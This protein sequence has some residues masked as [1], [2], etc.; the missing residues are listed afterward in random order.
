M[1]ESSRTT[2][3]PS[4]SLDLAGLREQVVGM[5]AN[6][7]TPFGQRLMVYCDYTASGRSLHFIERYLQGLLQT[8]ANTHTEDD[9]TGRSTSQLLHEAER[10]IKR[11]AGAGERGKIVACG[12]GATGAIHKLQQIL[13]VAIAP[14]TRSLLEAQ[15][16][17]HFG[18]KRAAAFTEAQAASQPVVFV[19]PYEHHSNEIS[20][21]QGLA[22]VVEVRLAHDG[23]V[24]LEHLE[25][26][27]T[28]PR[29]AGRLR[30]GSFSAASNVTGMRS[31]VR[32]IARLLHR[33]DALAC[34]DYAASGPYVQIDMNPGDDDWLDAVFISPHKFLG[35]PGSSGILVFNERLYHRELAP[36]VAGGGTV[37]YVSPEDHD[38]IADIEERE[39]A[40]TPGIL[41]TLRAALAFEVKEAVTHEAI[42]SRELALLQR[43]FA[44]W[45]EADG[46]EIL[47]NP[48]PA[49]RIGIVSFNVRDA[50]GGYLHPKFATALL[51]DLFGIQSRAGCSCAG[52]YGHRLLGIGTDV[53]G[54]Y[55]D[56]V[57]KGYHGIKPGWCRIGFHYV[58]DDVDADYVIAAVRFIARSGHRFLPDYCFDP[59]SGAWLHRKAGPVGTS[60]SLAAA[61]A[62]AVPGLTALP[63][64]ERA[65]RFAGYL[66]EAE[67]LAQAAG[68][69][70]RAGEPLLGGQFGALQFFST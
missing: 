13:G 49:R 43:A 10:A 1:N 11:A 30:I 26:L 55:R 25:A 31:P 29:Y 58:M 62:A 21:R 4:P 33:H 8:Y 5:D 50:R 39:R 35:G 44:Q 45:S 16:E 37:D 68:E 61:L 52:P 3:L 12:T 36:S 48:D 9:V 34:F 40:G 23:S 59:I 6:I 18:K 69:P 17:R 54:Q 65:R 47:G 51:N 70:M 19:G 15:I 64:T 7:D 2:Q 41:Q 67:A 66:A 20:W 56:W 24:D 14:A 63:A 27:L 53:S 22:T 28:E 60:F 46:I 32:E 42:E 57:R 38:F